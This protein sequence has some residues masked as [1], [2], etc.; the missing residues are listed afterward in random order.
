MA[1]INVGVIGLGRLGGSVALAVKRY[2]QGGSNRQ[3]FTVTGYDVRPDV[4]R[5]AK[6]MGAFEEITGS[7]SAAVRNKEIVVLALPYADVR[8]A[9]ALMEGQLK[10]GAVVIDFS[11]LSVPPLEWA[12]PLETS[13]VHLVG[14]TPVLNS[15]YLFDGK[16]DIRHAAAD[17]FL[18]GAM[19]LSPSVKAHPEAVELAADFS[20]VLGATPRFVDPHEHDGWMASVE[21]LPMLLGVAGFMAA[22]SLEGWDEAQRAANANFGRLTH[23]LADG[24]PDDLRA[25][26]LQN[27]D[28]AVRMIDAQIGVLRELRQ[29]VAAAD[30]HALAEAF[31]GEFDAYNIWLSRRISGQWESVEEKPRVNPGE[32]VMSGFLGGYLSRRL[33]G[34]KNASDD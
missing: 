30:E 1:V 5:V 2:Q 27:K 4:V 23:G 9:Y 10:P 16:D 7:L 15:D 11:M 33:R 28:A 20:A 18:S 29:V 17:L 12:T 8:E 6:T 34:G 19:L 14:A 13:D 24:Y 3:P 25:L 21:L 26:L 32:A 22:R 31:E